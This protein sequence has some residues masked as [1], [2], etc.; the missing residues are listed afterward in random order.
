MS[1]PPSSSIVAPIM[2]GRRAGRLAVCPRV[3]SA[4]APC[5]RRTVEP[6]VP[7]AEASGRLWANRRLVPVTHHYRLSIACLTEASSTH[8]TNTRIAWSRSASSGN[9]GASR[10]LESSGSRP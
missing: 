1:T 6:L 4:V 3:D 7:G 8:T 10:M 5:N 2:P 9:V